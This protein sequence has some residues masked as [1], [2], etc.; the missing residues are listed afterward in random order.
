MRP[1]TT[2]ATQP[3][4]HFESSLSCGDPVEISDNGALDPVKA[5]KLVCRLAMGA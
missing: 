3:V 5:W 2:N 1:I 4:P